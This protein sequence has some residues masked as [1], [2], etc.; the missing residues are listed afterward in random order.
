MTNENKLE[1]VKRIISSCTTPEHIQC[2]M[3]LQNCFKDIA[4]KSMVVSL[5]S[6]QLS[7]LR[8]EMYQEHNQFIKELTK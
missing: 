8:K 3:N 7:K 2:S 4:Y 5:C 6:I 1:H